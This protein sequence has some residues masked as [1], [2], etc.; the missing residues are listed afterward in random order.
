MIGTSLDLS[1]PIARSP[2]LRES[3]ELHPMRHVITRVYLYSNMLIT[4]ARCY[5]IDN[6]NSVQVRAQ[7]GHSDD[8]E[9]EIGTLG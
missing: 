4:F 9:S 6:R 2:S 7:G 1:A 5:S 3:R 8:L